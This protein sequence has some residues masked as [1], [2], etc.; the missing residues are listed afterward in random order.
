[1]SLWRAPGAT[2]RAAKSAACCRMRRWVSFSSKSTSASGG[3]RA[4]R[5]P[6]GRSMERPYKTLATPDLPLR[7]VCEEAPPRLP[8]QVARPHHLAQEEAGPVA[9]VAQLAE[10]G[11]GLG[12]VDVHPDQVDELERPH[13]EPRPEL[14][15]LVDVLRRGGPLGVDLDRLV[16]QPRQD[17]APDPRRAV[18]ARH[19]GL[20]AQ[21][22]GEGL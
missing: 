5:L 16:Q 4:L 11:L 8:P 3:K 17:A 20:L 19:D 21:P 13:R 18:E 9:R 22:L 15:R 2:R 1:M 12:E 6:Q 10:E 14:H 7:P